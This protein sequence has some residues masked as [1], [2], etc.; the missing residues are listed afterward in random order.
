MD[1]DRS[2]PVFELENALAE[3]V[4][5]DHARVVIEAPTGSGKSTQVPQMLADLP[6]SHDG[7]IYVLQPRRLAARMLA[8]RVARERNVR[9]GTEVGYQVRFENQLSPETRIRYVTEGILI[10]RLIDDPDLAG[11][12]A[13]VLDE[14]HE[15]HFY[16]DVSLARCLE[17]QKTLR[18]DL[19]IIAMSATLE[20]RSLISYLGDDS[21][22]LQSKGRTFPVEIKYSPPR[23]RHKGQIWD[24]IVR[25]MRDHFKTRGVEG[26]SLVF[27]P[28]QHEIRKTVDA[29]R[30]TSWTKGFEIH[31]L[32]GELPPEKQDAAVSAGSAPRIVVST[33]VAETSITIDGVTLVVDSGLERR[34]AFDSRRGLNTL[35]IEKISQA[36]ADQ[37]AGR[38]GRT[39]RGTAIRLWSER[40]HEQ[41]NRLTPAEIQRMDLSEAI[42]ILKASGVEKIA[43]FPWF[44]KPDPKA[45]E[46]ALRWLRHLGALDENES[47][48]EIGKQIGKIPVN[49]RFGRILVEAARR[50]CLE[51]FAFISAMVGNR[52]LFLRGKGAA[53]Q[54]DWI[55]FRHP[56]D[57]SD[58]Q[59]HYRAWSQMKESRFDFE[60][61]QRMGINA[62][63]ARNIDRVTRQFIRISSRFG[64]GGDQS[65]LPD[66]ETLGQI[67]LTGFSDRLAKKLSQATLA[68]AVV[69]G[70]RGL[71]DRESI[72]AKDD[73]LFIAGEMIEIEGKD[74][75]V[76]L[77]LSTR[78]EEA[79]VRD[80]FPDD[81]VEKDGAVYD[82]QTRR[83][84]ARKEL[85]FRD[86][87]LETKQSGTPPPEEAAA[88]LAGK[89][90]SDELNLKSWDRSIQEYIAR[91][92][93]VAATFPAYEIPA[94]DEE[95]Q[96]LLLEQICAGARSYKEIKD[97]P[98]KPAL[99]EWLLPHQAHLL[100]QLAP[101]R[102]EL[103][104]GKRVRVFYSTG[105]KPRVSVL[106]QHLFGLKDSPRICEGKVGLV[107]EILA[108][109][110]RPVQVTED[111]A[112]F[113]T[114]SYP[115]VRAQ[116]RGRYP[117]HEWPEY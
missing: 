110:H 69:G 22:H 115:A 4:A 75:N 31:E 39:G 67:L 111:L 33:N 53:S 101:E 50:G 107:V 74:L 32:Y 17:V 41:R 47:L 60:R 19:R 13:V 24:H 11:V 10:R 9:L 68:C 89:V 109:N 114:G 70:R 113:W 16:G 7:E 1:R 116:L 21:V 55:D 106:I 26:H 45:L 99:K 95:A 72:A 65:R 94:L 93:L 3:A 117:K 105:E 103:S 66:D 59:A 112:G 61:C 98:S 8:T 64:D 76:R 102:I 86:L 96:L 56:D 73:S 25:V 88:I 27:L 83:I 62:A 81:F 92:N 14:F 36:S 37:R 90:F 2:L 71:M 38:A 52:P 34:A 79:W 51:F 80:L 104:S 15:R 57:I 29:L 48:T 42:L 87:I 49:P 20:T 97:R 82:E 85:R 35:H 28:G 78:V 91:V 12:F 18:P 44:E 40:D 5:S 58:F 84:E 108:P 46:G 54:A 77:T 6:A 23:E 100:D 43:E 63:A 30:K